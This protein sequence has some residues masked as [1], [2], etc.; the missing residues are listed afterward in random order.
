MT[1]FLP[2]TMPEDIVRNPSPTRALSYTQ[3]PDGKSTV[4][5]DQQQTRG[6]GASTTAGGPAYDAN[7]PAVMDERNGIGYANVS[8]PT[9]AIQAVSF[10]DTKNPRQMLPYTLGTEVASRTVNGGGLHSSRGVELNMTAS[11]ANN[12]IDFSSNSTRDID[13]SGTRGVEPLSGTAMNTTY[14][15]IAEGPTNVSP[16]Y[17]YNF[18]GACGVDH[19]NGISYSAE[20]SPRAITST[21][22]HVQMSRSLEGLTGTS[23]VKATTAGGRTSPGLDYNY[24]GPVHVDTRNGLQYASP[25]RL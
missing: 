11:G 22:D 21:Y 9:R 5:F 6:F 1:S 25:A 13:F 8:N 4:Q 10:V 16:G 3:G 24:A 18:P 17:A 20:N 2:Y 12:T 14:S 19:R 7:M 23:I 15:T